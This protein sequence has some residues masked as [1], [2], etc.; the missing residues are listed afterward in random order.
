MKFFLAV[1]LII[2]LAHPDLRAGE[3]LSS[4]CTWKPKLPVTIS[5][6]QDNREPTLSTATNPSDAEFLVKV[7]GRVYFYSLPDKSCKT[8]LFIVY[9]D[10]VSAVDYFPERGG[11]YTDFARVSYYSKSRKG[12]ITGW[13]E[14]DNL[15]R[16]N[17]NGHCPSENNLKP[18]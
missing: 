6:L 13:I 1:T 18:K 14:M 8:D 3:I 9:R 7:K 5:E 11:G 10:Q 12:Y 15:C 17:F 4:N 2:I 16:L